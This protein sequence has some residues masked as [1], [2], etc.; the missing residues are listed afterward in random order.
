[1]NFLID[2]VCTLLV[3]I[4]IFATG[5]IIICAVEHANLTATINKKVIKTFARKTLKR[6]FKI[7]T[8]FG[9]IVFTCLALRSFLKDQNLLHLLLSVGIYK[10]LI[11]TTFW[12][13]SYLLPS[14]E[15]R[16]AKKKI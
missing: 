7:S 16:F 15:K 5:V 8:I 9:L 6:L 11:V 14:K 10:I 3:I 13:V 12:I 1:M 4:S 2:L